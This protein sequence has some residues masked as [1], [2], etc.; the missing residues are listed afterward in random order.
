L[1][2]NKGRRVY[3][4]RRKIVL[5]FFEGS[6]ISRL[7]KTIKQLNE[8]S[9]YL[10][11]VIAFSPK[12]GKEL[13]DH[14]IGHET[15]DVFYPREKDMLIGQQVS[16]IVKNWYK[17]SNLCKIVF[18]NGV[19]LGNLLEDSFFDYLLNVLM[20][21]ETWFSIINK[22]KPDDV[23]IF[24]NGSFSSEIGQRITEEL[25]VGLHV[26]RPVLFQTFLFSVKK[27]AWNVFKRLYYSR[28]QRYRLLFYERWLNRGLIRQEGYGKKRRILFVFTSGG[29]SGFMTL[30]PIIEHLR[31]LPEVEVTVITNNFGA[32]NKLKQKNVPFLT[33]ENLEVSSK[34]NESINRKGERL[35]GFWKA[36]KQSVTF[37]DLFQ[38]GGFNF[39]SYVEEEFSFNLRYGTT[40]LMRYITGLAAYLSKKKVDAI[41]V[42]HDDHTLGRLAVKVAKKLDIP[43]L[44]VIHNPA[45]SFCIRQLPIYATKAAV[46]GELH[47]SEF[48]K[49]KVPSSKLIVTGCPRFDEYVKKPLFAREAVFKML[50][51]NQDKKTIL[52]A[53]D[54]IEAN[55]QMELVMLSISLLK[56][57][58][59]IQIVIKLHPDDKDPEF[60]HPIIKSIDPSESIVLTKDS[61]LFSLLNIS[62][63][64][65]VDSST[66][67][68]E[69]IILGKPVI[70]ANF[71]HSLKSFSYAESGAALG[72]YTPEDFAEAVEKVLHD[73]AVQE[74]LRVARE[75]FVY[76]YAF[77]LDGAAS[78]RISDLL[79]EFD[80]IVKSEIPATEAF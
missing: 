31:S 73:R 24:G 33:F 66:V 42:S 37:T 28:L 22:E 21:I 64:V 5:A 47:K 17:S 74:R 71:S 35:A 46:W 53:P 43:S 20:T 79:M 58:N 54:P 78:K 1:R 39:W 65:I 16:W 11:K 27:Q 14:K 29:T 23:F 50:N 77:K 76:E 69:A 68:L 9:E 19:S 60:Y 75:K 3:L 49:K 57:I 15:S 41:V 67:G 13:R 62:D 59:N 12:S 80:R 38:Y 6:D 10:V 70:A 4:S 48:V 30:Y 26:Y 32:M 45:T 44:L 63:I 25:K 51:L 55:K 18:F 40:P 7:Q 52:L 56:K 2:R 61:D 34:V 8:N 36:A 72:V